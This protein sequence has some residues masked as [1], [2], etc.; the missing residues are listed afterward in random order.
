MKAVV[1]IS[2]A[3]PDFK[4]S[5]V[6]SMLEKAKQF[7]KQ[8]G[9]TGCILYHKD[10]FI[11]LIE[12]EAGAIDALYDRIKQ[13]VRH[14]RVTT[15]YYGTIGERLFEQWSMVFY[16]FSGDQESLNYKRLLFE[17]YLDSAEISENNEEVFHVFRISSEKLLQADFRDLFE[18]VELIFPDREGLKR[19]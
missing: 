3:R 13:D 14:E 16:E 10:T 18:V 6:I 5:G 9:I 19:P 11:Q 2:K 4:L 7:N 1:Y 12:G 8:E 15:L 17:N